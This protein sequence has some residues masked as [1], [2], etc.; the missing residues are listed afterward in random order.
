MS[1]ATTEE[2]VSLGA[3][4]FAKCHHQPLEQT[5][6]VAPKGRHSTSEP[7]TDSFEIALPVLLSVNSETE[8]DRGQT[9][10]FVMNHQ[11]LKAGKCPSVMIE[12]EF[13]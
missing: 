3:R 13:R 11:P 1:S 5:L 12:L 8:R 4:F 7:D 2:Y 10:R 6:S 9:G